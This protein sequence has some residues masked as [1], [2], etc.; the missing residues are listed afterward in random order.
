MTNF[1]HN[2]K[3][4]ARRHR[5]FLATACMHFLMDALRLTR[6]L[7]CCSASQ[8]HLQKA[9][10]D[11]PLASCSSASVPPRALHCSCWPAGRPPA[12]WQP[13]C[14]HS[15]QPCSSA[16]PPLIGLHCPP[17]GLCSPPAALSAARTMDVPQLGCGAIA[18]SFLRAAFHTVVLSNPAKLHC[19]TLCSG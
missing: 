10:L 17:A 15:S 4:A 6:L 9:A 13:C 16:P 19:K 12:L 7:G 11:I 14:P 3:S 5:V 1:G 18:V 8:A 2:H